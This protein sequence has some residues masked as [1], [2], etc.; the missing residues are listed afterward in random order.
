MRPMFCGTPVTFSESL[1]KLPHDIRKVRPTISIQIS[2]D[3]RSCTL[4]HGIGRRRKERSS[5]GSQKRAYGAVR[6]VGDCEVQFPVLHKAADDEVTVPAVHLI[7][8]ASRDDVRMREIQESLGV[9]FL[10]VEFSDPRDGLRQCED[11]QGASLLNRFDLG[12]GL[13]TS[14]QVE[15]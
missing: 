2:N 3:D 5:S 13:K 1:L 12:R 7:E 10:N 6:V 9:D 11:A 8:H 14:G 4:V 15:E